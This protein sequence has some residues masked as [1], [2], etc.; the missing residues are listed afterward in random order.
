[1]PIMESSDKL[2]RLKEEESRALA[3]LKKKRLGI[4]QTDGQTQSRYP[5]GRFE[6]ENEIELL[7]IRLA[8]IRGEIEDIKKR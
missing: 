5:S 1:M 7:E 4:G 3:R 8:R 6:L 2:E